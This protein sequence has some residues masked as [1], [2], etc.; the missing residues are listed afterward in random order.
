MKIDLPDRRQN[1]TLTLMHSG[2]QFEVTAGYDAVGQVK[3]VFCSGHKESAIEHLA[4]DACV[5]IS[6]ALQSGLAPSD[7]YRSLGRVPV[8]G[9][10]DQTE[11][12]SLIGAILEALE[13]RPELAQL[14]VTE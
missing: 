7:L 3:E 5:L 6:I 9:T 12:A 11:P 14:C 4:S 13:P 10:E 2:R 8:L 1:T